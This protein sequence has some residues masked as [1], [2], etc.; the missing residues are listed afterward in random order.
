MPRTRGPAPYLILR[1]WRIGDARAAVAALEASGLSTKAF[2]ARECLD[3]NRLYRWRRRLG[4]ERVGDEG[5]EF[6][7]LRPRGADRVEVVLRS[8][9]VLRVAETIDPKA[10]ARIVAALEQSGPC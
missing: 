8:G 1:R 9:H 6:V 10:L 2:A 3:V 7:E 4:A 5:P